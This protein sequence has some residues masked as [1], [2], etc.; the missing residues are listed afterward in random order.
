MTDRRRP[1]GTGSIRQ[2]GSRYQATYSYVD[3]TGTRRRRS[4]R[5]DTRT[6]ARKWLN[7]RL[8]EVTQGRTSNVSASTLDE[9]LT[10]WVAALR[11]TGLE[12]TTLNWY[13][14]A[15]ETHIVPALGR[16][17]LDRLSPT[18]IDAFLATK[19]ESGRIDGKGG[20]GPTSIRRLRTTLSKALSDAVR[21][22]LITENPMKRVD[23]LRIPRSDVTATVWSPETI[24]TFLAATR[25]DRL[26]P[27]WRLA[28]MTGLRREELAALKWPDLDLKAGVVSIRRARVD[29]GGEVIVKGPKSPASRR[30]VDLDAETLA[31]LRRWR[32]RQV[33]ERLTAGPAWEPGEWVFADKIGRPWRPDGITYRFTKAIKSAGVPP[34]DIRGLRH[35]HATALLATGAH[36]KIVQ[37]RL[38][39]SSIKVT[40]DIYSSVLPGIQRE[41]VERLA[42]TI[43]EGVQA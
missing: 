30:L 3:G 2:R 17:R 4:K 32:K 33:K 29:V 5:F 9:Y 6:D 11:L 18:R 23:P 38:G 43:D 36:P 39:H 12:P 16:V 1:K 40:M 26:F 10:E 22:G 31:V 24:S 20:L 34:T 42:S 14:S 15:V 37:E 27:L 7:A 35:A 28:A 19:A 25:T 41:A 13:R 21:K 8:N